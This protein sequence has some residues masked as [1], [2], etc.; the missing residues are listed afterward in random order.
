LLHEGLCCLTLAAARQEEL[1]DRAVRDDAR[2]VLADLGR[3]RVPEVIPDAYR[4]ARGAAWKFEML[5]VLRVVELTRIFFGDD[6]VD[7]CLGCFD[8]R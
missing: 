6:E 2:P 7:A 5:V 4:R 8:R 3:R 1:R